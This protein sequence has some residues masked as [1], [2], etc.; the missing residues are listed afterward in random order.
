VRLVAALALAAA[1]LLTW[2]ALQVGPLPDFEPTRLSSAA[3]PARRV[4]SL[5]AEADE[6]VLELA[7]PGRMVC[8]TYMSSIHDASNVVELAKL[9]GVKISNI[10]QVEPIVLLEP[11]LVVVN[12]FNR[13]E[14]LFLMEQAGLRVH[15]LRYPRSIEDVRS[16]LIHLGR[17][18]GEE[19]AA[20]RWVSEI[21][22]VS[23]ECRARTRGRPRIRTLVLSGSLWAEGEGT[24][25]DDLIRTAGGENVMA[26]GSRV[27]S[28]EEIIFMNP[29]AVVLTESG[30]NLFQG[31]PALASLPAR[32]F[33]VPWRDSQPPTQY[34]IRAIRSWAVRLHPEAFAG[35][36]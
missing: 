11:D 26:E 20:A 24:L 3:P 4:A 16:N 7:G 5:A 34:V 12:D 29:E 8:A 18:L 28:P 9:V 25:V 23:H 6:M 22:G 21:D 14:A 1:C 27:V 32:K 13:P 10:A 36:K 31:D 35:W 33:V 2:E 19:G 30:L 17:A 15:R